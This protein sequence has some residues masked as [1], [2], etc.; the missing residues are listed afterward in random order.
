MALDPDLN[1]EIPTGEQD[2]ETTNI[3]DITEMQSEAASLNVPL[4]FISNVLIEEDPIYGS[5][6]PMESVLHA[7]PELVLMDQRADGK[8]TTTPSTEGIVSSS[9]TMRVTL[10]DLVLQGTEHLVLGSH[11]IPEYMLQ[12]GFPMQSLRS[13][14][15]ECNGKVSRLYILSSEPCTKEATT[16]IPP[17][18]DG[19]IETHKLPVEVKP[20]PFTSMV[21]SMDRN[22]DKENLRDDAS[23][24]STSVSTMPTSASPD[25]AIMREYLELKINNITIPVLT[26]GSK[27][28]G[29][30]HSRKA[31]AQK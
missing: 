25:T 3:V 31:S 12:P 10:R 19:A 24:C 9:T 17:P 1:W 8:P 21:T 16:Y 5:L 29:T 13:V 27:K 11:I 30:K 20:P 14:V 18:G 4:P 26:A 2:L 22:D 6:V 23:S 7:P 15:A 28:F